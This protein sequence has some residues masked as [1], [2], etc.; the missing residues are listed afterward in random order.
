MVKFHIIT[1]SCHPLNSPQCNFHT[2]AFETKV[3]RQSHRSSI[4]VLR[5]RNEPPKVVKYRSFKLYIRQATAL[6]LTAYW[7]PH[8]S[9]NDRTN[10]LTTN[11]GIRFI[12]KGSSN[13]KKSLFILHDYSIKTSVGP[14][15]HNIAQE[16]FLSLP[17]SHSVL[18]INARIPYNVSNKDPHFRK[19]RIYVSRIPFLGLDA[20]M[21]MRS[22]RR[23]RSYG[24]AKLQKCV[25]T[26][27]FRTCSQRRAFFETQGPSRE[28]YLVQG[29]RRPGRGPTGCQ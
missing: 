18:D 20:E 24:P 23:K 13:Y 25:E 7:V 11:R 14:T 17:R 6:L 22:Q 29:F 4:I 28:P 27:Y 19:Y 3:L 8:Y 1:G 5:R 10:E 21:L 16:T 15:L 2:I 26:F 12:S 9:D